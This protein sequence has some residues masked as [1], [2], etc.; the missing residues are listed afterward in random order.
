M[1]NRLWIRL[2]YAVSV[3]RRFSTR[4][5]GICHFF[6]RYCGIG[7]PPMSPSWNWI[8]F[9]FRDVPSLCFK[10]R[11]SAK[12]IFIPMQ[13]NLISQERFCTSFVMKVRVF[14]TGKWP[15]SLFVVK[16]LTQLDV[17]STYNDLNWNKALFHQACS[18]MTKHGS[19][20]FYILLPS[21]LY[22]LSGLR[23]K[24]TVKE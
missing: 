23:N 4:Y 24:A 13:I 17:Y 5:F 1:R 12:R 14:G 18:V 6:L 22:S 20:S 10:A 19:N 9:P 2:I 8:H 3:F 11:L 7:Y 15:I 21:S 16:C